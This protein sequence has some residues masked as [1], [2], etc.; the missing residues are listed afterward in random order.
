[1]AAMRAMATA[2]GR[3]SEDV[4]LLVRA[5]LHITPES[6]GDERFV[7]TGSLREIASDVEACVDMGAAELFFDMTFTP[8][9]STL[10]GL[11]TYMEILLE[12]AR[13]AVALAR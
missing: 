6:L 9:G 3:S 2:A 4:S 13:P 7:F 1:L 10:N 12:A 8:Q 5:N 11:F